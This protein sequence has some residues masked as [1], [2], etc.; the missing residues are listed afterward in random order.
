M[1]KFS[2]SPSR[3]WRWPR[4]AQVSNQLNLVNVGTGGNTGTG[5]PLRTAFQK[6]N[7]NLLTIAAAIDA[8]PAGSSVTNIVFTNTTTLPAGSSVTV[9]NLG[10]VGGIAFFSSASPLARPERPAHRE[11]IPSRLTAPRMRFILQRK[12]PCLTPIL[13]LPP[14]IIGRF[15]NVVQVRINA[16][17][18]RWRWCQSANLG[19]RHH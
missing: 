6:I 4:P 10:V 16:P 14:A 7:T 19:A 5:D 15:T 11:R 2:F 17:R 12:S 9:T 8:L 18:S 13:I 3:S 1:K